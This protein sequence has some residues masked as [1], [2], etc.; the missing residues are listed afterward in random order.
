MN[1]D[2]R[3]AP[4]EVEPVLRVLPNLEIAATGPGLE[5]SDRLALNAYATPVSDFVWRLE[6]SQLLTAI[7]AGR[8]VGEIRAFPA[9]RSGTALPA[10]VAHLLDDVAGRATLLQDRG[11]ARLIECDDA[12]LAAL[13]ANDTRTRKHCTLFG[14][15]RLIGCGVPAR[16]AGCRLPSGRG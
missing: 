11:L 12:A 13:I 6:A 10:T 9:A 16:L 14:G 7:D 3:P 5:Q 15:D 1:T 8:Q 4:I 2:Y